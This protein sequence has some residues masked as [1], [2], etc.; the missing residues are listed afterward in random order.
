M[1]Q[2]YGNLGI[3]YKTRGELDKAEEVWKK[4]LRL[5]QAMGHPNAKKVQQLL[6]DLAQ[7]RTTSTQ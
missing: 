1:A 4:S 7:Q 2:D 5:Y 6:D 3:V